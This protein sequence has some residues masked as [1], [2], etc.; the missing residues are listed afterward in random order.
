[1]YMLTSDLRLPPVQYPAAS[2]GPYR[3]TDHDRLPERP[4]VELLFG[5]LV[6]V[7]S[8]SPWHQTVVC[9]LWRRLQR[10]ASPARGRA[11]AAPL[12]VILADHSVVQPDLVYVSAARVDIVQDRIVGAPDLLIEVLS[13]GTMRRD[14][15]E[16]KTLYA[17]SGVPEYWLVDPASRRI[18]FQVNDRGRFMTP[19][20]V[21]GPYASLRL[22]EL[23][24]DPADLWREIDSEA[25]L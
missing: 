25:R 22:P 15:H 21:A 8:P 5:N 20:S 16:K 1:M 17:L 2:L 7:P 3:Q 24:L 4:R 10:I 11:Y 12:D 13:P 9:F 18:E 6:P 19:A 23:R 14:T